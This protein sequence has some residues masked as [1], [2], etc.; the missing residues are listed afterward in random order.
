MM[1]FVAALWNQ[2]KLDECALAGR[3][4]MQL[5]ARCGWKPEI[6]VPG[7]LLFCFGLGSDSN[8]FYR[9]PDNAGGVIGVLFDRIRK[10]EEIPQRLGDIPPSAGRKIQK[11]AGCELIQS[12]W[13]RFVGFICD[14]AACRTWVLQDPSASQPLFHAVREGVHVYF[15]DLDDVRDLDVFS[16]SL[17][18]DYLRAY[19]LHSICPCEATGLAQVDELQGGQ[20]HEYDGSQVIS[21]QYW[22][23]RSFTLDRIED[24]GEACAQL[25][26]TVFACTQAWASC[27]DTV[28]HLLSGGLDSSI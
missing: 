21:K 8:R 13:G 22:L 1:R 2:A 11:T 3:F 26:A 25:R 24:P 19:V 9:L 27:F 20:C 10:G 5:R 18:L 7:L 15:S 16:F 28:V 6:E 12:Y 17:N 23:P 4:A 14:P